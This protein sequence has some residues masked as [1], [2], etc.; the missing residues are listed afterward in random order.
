MQSNIYRV[1]SEK[2]AE[3]ATQLAEESR[4]LFDANR[5]PR[6]YYLAHMSTEESAKSILLHAM[7]VSGTPVREMHK[8]KALLR[9][10]KKKI[11]F[12]VSYGASLSSSVKN[13]LGEL[14]SDLISYI[15]NLKNDT[16]YVSCVR[17]SIFTPTQ[18]V[19]GIPVAAHVDV[20]RNLAALASS[21]LTLPSRPSNS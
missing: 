11:E 18:K 12:I 19:S 21:L 17:D 9:D 7:S 4:I 20:A 10:H 15:N 2:A 14:Q 1:W 3:N 6:A 8:V 13:Q 16:M 5:L